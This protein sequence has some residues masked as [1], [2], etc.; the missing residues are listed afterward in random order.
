MALDL[1]LVP[2]DCWHTLGKGS[3]GQRK[4]QPGIPG[5]RTGPGTHSSL[6]WA[7]WQEEVW[8]EAQERR[9]PD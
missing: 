8:G 5:C 1:L 6:G 7:R 4:R 2:P 9:D 3:C